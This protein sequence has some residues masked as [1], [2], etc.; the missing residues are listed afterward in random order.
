M[1]AF[2]ALATIL[3]LGL[4]VSACDSSGTR[5]QYGAPAATGQS[6]DRRAPSAAPTS[7]TEP[8]TRDQAGGA[9]GSY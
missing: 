7:R 6:P 9:G 2:P 1:T 5:T 3:A 4:A 8:E